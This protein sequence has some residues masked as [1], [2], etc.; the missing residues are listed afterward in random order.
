MPFGKYLFATRWEYICSTRT[1]TSCCY[2]S[3]DSKMNCSV[4][5]FS[6][7]KKYL[8]SEMKRGKK[9]TDGIYNEMKLLYRCEFKFVKAIIFEL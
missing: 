9:L 4:E 5:A 6:E 8:L 2:R 1:T 7:L 3:M